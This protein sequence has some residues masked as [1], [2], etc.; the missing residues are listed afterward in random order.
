MLL[1][2]APGPSATRTRASSD[3][4]TRTAP[5][6]TAMVAGTAPPPRTAASIRRAV[7][8]LVADGSPWLMIVDSRA[9]TPRPEAI[10]SATSSATTMRGED[11]DALMA[12]HCARAWGRAGLAGLNLGRRTSGAGRVSGRRDARRH[13]GDAATPQRR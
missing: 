8:A 1:F 13:R 9:T 7:A 3:R 5:S 4:P 12:R 6:T 2:T 10:A 11:P